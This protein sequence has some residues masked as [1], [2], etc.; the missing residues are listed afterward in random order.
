[1]NNCRSISLQEKGKCTANY[2]ITRR[3]LCNSPSG[4][5]F[6]KIPQ[7]AR[8][9]NYILNFLALVLHGCEH[10]PSH[11]TSAGEGLGHTPIKKPSLQALYKCIHHSI[12][13]VYFKNPSVF[14][15]VGYILHIEMGRWDGIPKKGIHILSEY[16]SNIDLEPDE[17]HKICF[18]AFRGGNGILGS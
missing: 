9:M 3:V 5:R 14:V 8:S 13:N 17:F 10:L 16:L 11:R 15:L 7:D 12:M 6:K 2:L 18:P 4:Q 1:M